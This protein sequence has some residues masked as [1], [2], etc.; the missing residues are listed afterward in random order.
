M[1]NKYECASDSS[2]DEVT[3]GWF[4]PIYGPGYVIGD[5]YEVNGEGAREHNVK[6]TVYEMELLCEH[7]AKEI[8]T[9][10]EMWRYYECTGSREIRIQPYA[11][12]RLDYFA[13]FLGEEKVVEIET[14]VYK[15]SD[16]PNEPYGYEE[17]QRGRISRPSD[18]LSGVFDRVLR[19]RVRFPSIGK[20]WR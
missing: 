20:E 7:W 16:P 8:R 13:K 11:S 17:E 15:G 9:V 2:F 4:A 1:E 12:M 19:W 3:D 10:R 18:V 6:A 5:I 14:E